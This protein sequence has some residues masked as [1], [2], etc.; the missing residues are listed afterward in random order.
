MTVRGMGLAQEQSRSVERDSAR[1]SH[2]PGAPSLRGLRAANGQGWEVFRRTLEPRWTGVWFDLAL[3]YALLAGGFA[4]ACLIAATAGN[5]IGFLLAPF[6]ALWMGFWFASIVLFMHEGAHF[7]LHPDK[8]RNDRM[9]QWLVCILIGDD[10]RRYRAVHWEHHL[11]LGDQEDTEVSYHF[12]PTLRCALENL[13]GVHVWRVFKEHH[14]DRAAGGQAAAG[15][16]RGWLGLA[17]GVV[18]HAMIVL[19]AVMAG[20]YSAAAAWVLAV[21][22]CFPFFSALRNQLEHRSVD[23]S[24]DVDYRVTPHGAVNRM[25]ASSPFARAFGSTGFRRHLLHH[26]DP[27]ISYSRFDEFE[28]FLMQTD[29]APE[30]DEAR[31]TYMSIW[32]V[33]AAPPVESQSR[34][35]AP[36]G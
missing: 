18:L 28:A 26:W 9:A 5:T 36:A 22:V 13:I 3:R 1:A 33:L 16:A 35:E 10:I 4:A 21:G 14:R 17:S 25:F 7:N 27:Q 23:A 15:P 30:I 12:A 11:H 20:W 19:S 34:A 29:L 31:T 32:R 6:T 2:L 24:P 8:R